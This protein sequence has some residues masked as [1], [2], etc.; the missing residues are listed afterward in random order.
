M[1]KNLVIVESPAKAKTIKKYLGKDYEVL[2]SYGHVRDLVPKDGAVDVTR[3]FGFL[4]ADQ[5]G[6]GDVLVHFSVLQA[7]GRRSLPEGA[8]IECR[9]VRRDRG[10]QA[11]EI[12]SIDL[13]AV[14]TY[15][16]VVDVLTAADITGIND[17][18][19]GG[20]HDEPLIATDRI[21]FHGQMVFAVAAETREIARAAARKAKFTYRDLPHATDILDARRLGYGLVT[22][23]L[24]LRRGDAD[25]ALAASPRTVKGAMRIGG[26]EHFYLEGHIALAIPGEDDEVTV[27]SS[28]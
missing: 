1:S 9:A 28:T 14:K 2:A 13:S 5:P 3:G 11:S 8:R 17:V 24:T 22:E 20:R 19:P 16:G 25:A 26:Q 6:L 18:S 7:H 15:P 23:P 27:W 12:L 21:E 4:V 10:L